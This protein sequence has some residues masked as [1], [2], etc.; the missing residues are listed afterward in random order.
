MSFEKCQQVEDS[1]FRAAVAFFSVGGDKEWK[2]R[3][4]I[5]FFGVYELCWARICFQETR[6]IGS[7]CTIV[8]VRDEESTGSR[9][10]SSNCRFVP[11]NDYHAAVGICVVTYSLFIACEGWCEMEKRTFERADATTARAYRGADEA[12]DS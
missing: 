3:P 11:D 1:I 7:A 4:A 12:L 2:L 10:D 5:Y 9:E 8:L 6:K